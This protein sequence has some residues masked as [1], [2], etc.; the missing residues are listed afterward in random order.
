MAARMEGTNMSLPN[1]TIEVK[2]TL[3]KKEKE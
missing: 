2:E 3:G 1:Q